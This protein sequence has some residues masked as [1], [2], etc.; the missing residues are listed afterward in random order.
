MNIGC[1]YKNQFMRTIVNI[2]MLLGAV[3]FLGSS[4]AKTKSTTAKCADDVICTMMFAMVNTDVVDNTGEH[5]IL[6]EAY[7]LRDDTGE[8]IKLEQTT[9]GTIYTVLDD[10]YVKK[11]Q[12]TEAKFHFV[13][14]KG[15]KQIVNEPYTISAD[16]CHIKKVSGKEQITV[17]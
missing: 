2:V 4:C 10:S 9:N 3:S 8:K 14:I 13:G 7:T 16:C 11:L 5:V 12:N 1:H 17:Q 15:G 6:D